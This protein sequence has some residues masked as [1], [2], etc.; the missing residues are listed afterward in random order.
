M[1]I[2]KTKKVK[3]FEIPTLGLGTWRMAGGARP[4]YSQDDKVFSAIRHAL[5][6]GYSHIDTAEL[7]GSGHIEELI[8][9]AIQE[10]DR[11]KLFITSKVLAEHLRYDDVLKAA[12][13]SLKRL[14]TDYLD[15]YLIHFSNPGIPIAE[16]MKAMDFLVKE[17]MMKFIGVSNFSMKQFKEAQACSVNRLVASQMEY[18]LTVRNKGKFTTNMESEMIPYCQKNEIIFMAWRPVG[19]GALARPG[20]PLLDEMAAKYGKKQAQIAINWLVSK[21]NV[22]TMPMSVGHEHLKENLGALDFALS[23]ADIKR[24]DEDF[25]PRDNF[26]G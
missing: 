16:T 12:E 2:P 4:D 15:L 24:L 23:A 13:G 22:V 7:Y 6:L 10:V 3:G 9:K 17:G 26:Y 1:P 5:K 18:N 11:R 14:G 19:Q 25:A 20:N 21:K 8:G